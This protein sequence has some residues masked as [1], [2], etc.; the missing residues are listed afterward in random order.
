MHEWMGCGP[1]AASQY[2]GQRY[3]RPA[4][5]EQW[6][7][8][9]ESGAPLREDEVVL[10]DR[11]LLTDAVLFGLRMNG[12]IDLDE[13]RGRFPDAG[14][15]GTLRVQLE[16]YLHEGLLNGVDGQF[17]LTQRGRLLA[18]AIGSDILETIN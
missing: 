2:A 5:L 7:T 3:Q 9:M 4:N 17:S 12:G 15:L 10:S 8:G 1:S 14:E 13:L 18:D 16:K 6:L 11:L